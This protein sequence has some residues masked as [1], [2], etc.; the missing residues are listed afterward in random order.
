MKYLIQEN[1]YS[2]RH[3]ETLLH[4]L[5]RMGLEYELVKLV[6]FENKLKF[7]KRGRPRQKNVFVFGAVKMAHIASEMGFTPGSMYNENHDFEVYGPKYGS[8]MLNHGAHI[9]NFDDPLPED[10]K[11]TMFFAR[12]CGD[13]KLFTGQVYMRHSWDEY[14]ADMLDES[15]KMFEKE[16]IEQ[17][18]ARIDKFRKS[19]VMLCE[20]KEIAYEVRCWVVGGKVITM[21][22]YKRGRRVV[23]TNVD[24]YDG[25]RQKVQSFVDMYQPA[26]AF[27]IDVCNLVGDGGT[28]KNLKIVEINCLNCSGFYDGNT[29]LML[30]A[31][32]EHFNCNTK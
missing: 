28:V 18:R 15:K 13:N 16:T 25:L 31:L 32:E 20:L 21:S 3:H 24:H 27:V 4:N 29:Q 23:Y 2:E 19:K 12:P 6:P 22:E 14:I 9:M 5:E 30:N 26:E 7:S 8:N 10:D 1:I 11:Y 17:V